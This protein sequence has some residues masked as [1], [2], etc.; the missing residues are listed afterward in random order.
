MKTFTMFKET[1]KT[2]YSKRLNGSVA[3]SMAVVLLLVFT[4]LSCNNKSK[5]TTSD[6]ES[7]A[8]LEEDVWV[9]G[10]HQINDIPLTSKAESTKAAEEELK[11]KAEAEEELEEKAEAEEDMEVE[12]EEEEDMEDEIVGED[13]EIATIEALAADLEEAEYEAMENVE[14]DEIAIPLDET[15]TMVSYSKKGKEKAELHV[16]SSIENGEIEQVIFTDKKHKDVY[17]VQAGM[18][19][20]EVKKLRREIKHMVRKGKVYLYDDSSNIMYLMDAQDIQGN[21]LTEADVENMDV[22]AIIW[23]DKK[24]H[25]K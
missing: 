23:K 5:K 21:E 13:Y 12:A 18:S 4:T 24:H 14:I 11:E 1:G 2:V 17:N 6:T 9:I 25:K 8:V 16:V 7:V 20:K 19:G 3:I 10:E 15:Q 22:Q